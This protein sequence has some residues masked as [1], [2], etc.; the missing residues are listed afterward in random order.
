MLYIAAVSPRANWRNND[1]ALP[2]FHGEAVLGARLAGCHSF[3]VS[4]LLILFSVLIFACNGY[5][6]AF[7]AHLIKMTTLVPRG[8]YS[9]A[10]LDK[11]Y[12]RNL[13]LQL[14]QVILRHGE[15]APVGARFQNA[16]L[17]PYWPYCNGIDINHCLT[18]LNLI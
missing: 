15:R 1:W 3:P 6:S 9:Q 7:S 10:E 2:T 11:L 14:V 8:P 13:E 4:R 17:A 18:K 5:T 16:G 12:P